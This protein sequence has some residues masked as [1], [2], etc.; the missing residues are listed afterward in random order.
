MHAHVAL[1]DAEKKEQRRRRKI[2]SAKRS[3]EK[4]RAEHEA[5]ER[6][7]VANN[8]RIRYLEGEVDRLTSELLSGPAPSAARRNSARPDWFGAPF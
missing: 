1:S 5:V 3:R 7:V 2:E 4:R 8:E 6:Q